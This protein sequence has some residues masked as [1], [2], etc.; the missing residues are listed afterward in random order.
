M[1]D[2][3]LVTILTQYHVSKGIKVSGEPGVEAVLKE[4][5]HIN[6]IMVMKPKTLKKYNT[7]LRRRPCNISSFKRKN[8]VEKLKGRVAQMGE[9]RE[10]ISPMMR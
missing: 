7:K 8:D 9:K 4:L 3:L 6:E 5:N 1:H 2:P 10:I